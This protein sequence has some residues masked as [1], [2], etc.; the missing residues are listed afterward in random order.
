MNAFIAAC[1][2]FIGN[3]LLGLVR[4][5]GEA[6]LA[7]M[8]GLGHAILHALHGAGGAVGRL[9][10]RVL[11]WVLVAGG[12]MWLF[13]NQPGVLAIFLELGIVFFGFWLIAKKMFPSRQ[14][15]RRRR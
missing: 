5:V 7:L 14:K 11:P 12:M 10:A 8:T 15:E 3:M 2:R 4:F 1:G 13:D 6:I 9:I